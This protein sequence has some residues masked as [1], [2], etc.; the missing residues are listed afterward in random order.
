MAVPA[1]PDASGAVQT[2]R[3]VAPA[4]G[5]DVPP[6]VTA[7]SAGGAVA[8]AVVFEIVTDPVEESEELVKVTAGRGP[9][10]PT[11]RLPAPTVP[12]AVKRA[13]QVA[14]AA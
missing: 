13:L 3:F 7:R 12:V 9:S 1:H 10:I 8:P 14:D 11:E 6:K 2:T 5:L 4:S